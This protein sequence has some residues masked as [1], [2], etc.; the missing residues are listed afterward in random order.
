MIVFYKNLVKVD[1]LYLSGEIT[2][3]EIAIQYA[4]HEVTRKLNL[5]TGCYSVFDH[6]TEKTFKIRKP[7]WMYSLEDGSEK[8]SPGSF[9]SS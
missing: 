6:V 1:P 9:S 2:A 4:S 8:S 3:L 7:T 5:S